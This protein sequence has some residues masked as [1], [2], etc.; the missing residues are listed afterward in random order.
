[1]YYVLCICVVSGVCMHGI[2]YV[3]QIYD[4]EQ[5]QKYRCYFSTTSDSII[6]LFLGLELIRIDHHWDTGFVLWSLLLCLVYRLIGNTSFSTV[7]STDS[8]ILIKVSPWSKT[9]HY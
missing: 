7:T 6:F 1:M 3:E 8:F 4:A 9:Y 5:K 2:S